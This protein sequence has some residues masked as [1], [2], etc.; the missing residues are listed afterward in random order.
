[1]LKE[2]DVAPKFALQADDGSTVRLS[3][4][5]GRTV[6]LY[7]YPKDDTPGCT[8]EACEFRDRNRDLDKS[9]A[10]VLGVSPDSVASHKRFREKYGLDFRLLA[11]P[12]HKVA[13]AYGVWQ[14][15]SMYGRKYWGIVRTTFVINER[16]R[17]A[18]VFE[19]VKPA[20]H[21]AEVLAA[22]AEHPNG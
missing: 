19:K 4:L 2:N 13:E 17:I 21:A 7:F 20:G 12:D 3:A 9:G 11:E 22:L 18:R 14:R 6:V 8:K 5:R 10:V 16:G 1:M 15:K